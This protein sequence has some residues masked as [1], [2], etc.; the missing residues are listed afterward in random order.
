MSTSSQRARAAAAAGVAV[1]AYPEAG[2]MVNPGA[3]RARCLAAAEAV[4]AQAAQV[5]WQA[6]AAAQE[7]AAMAAALRA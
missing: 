3:D 5:A 4:A 7:A 2:A 1:D 6:A